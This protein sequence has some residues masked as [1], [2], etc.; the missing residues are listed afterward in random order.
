[1]TVTSLDFFVLLVIGVLVYYLVPKRA[2][3]G[4]LLVLSITFYMFAANPYTLAYIIISALLAYVAGWTV[5]RKE[6]GKVN[7]G[8]TNIII[9][10][11]II[12]NILLWLILKGESFWLW[13][14][15]LLNRMNSLIK[16]PKSEFVAA[17]GMGYYTAQTIGYILDVH[18]GISKPE[19]NP[20]KV[21]LF[22]IFFPQL[23]V[24]PISKFSEL[25]NIYEAHDFTYKNI[26]FGTQ[27]ILWGLYKKLVIS[28]RVAIIVNAIWNDTLTY[29]GIWPWIAVLLY[30]LEI[31]T[32]FSGCMDIILGAAELFDIKMPENFKNPFYS[33]TIQ[34]FWQRWHITL[35]IWAKDYIYY[36]VLK[37]KMMIA[38]G[39]RA[40]SIFSKRMAKLIPWSIGMGILWLVMGVWHGSLKHVVGVSV[41]Y[42]MIITISE[43]LSPE[44][45]KVKNFLKI[46]VNVFSWKFFQRIRTYAI[47]SIG[48]VFFVAAGITD[49]FNRYK[50]LINSIKSPNLW[51]LFDG[52]IMSMNISWGD[53]NLIILGILSMIVVAY[54]REKYDYARNWMAIQILPFRWIAWLG[55]FT[56]V[57]IYGHYGAGYEA[58]QFIY[59]GF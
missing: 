39:K 42:W 49:V 33:L 36:P 7:K 43:A 38:I 16:I 22:V 25:Q 9:V 3:W 31:Y 52:T 47:F 17:L 58:S 26:C 44:F 20:L 45:K 54:L 48:C 24:G 5:S 4:V 41:W 8:V 18:W 34:E 40:R 57:L 12:I 15:Q 23:T 56:I 19:K 6:Q 10:G 1:M 46:D 51:T 21:L 53:I 29:N 11:A 32:D 55:L 35:G 59:Q 27:R 2:Q 37:S 28:D 13:G 14:F 50:I 30:P